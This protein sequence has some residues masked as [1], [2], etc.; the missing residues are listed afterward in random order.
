MSTTSDKFK[1]KMTDLL[2]S[3]ELSNGKLPIE[4]ESRFVAELDALWWGMTDEEHEEA[5]KF[6]SRIPSA[7]NALGLEDIEAASGMPPRMPS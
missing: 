6:F 1:A 7:P 4:T 3:R 2:F 5:E